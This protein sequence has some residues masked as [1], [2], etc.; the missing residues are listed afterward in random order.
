MPF[1]KQRWDQLW[2]DLYRW[3]SDVEDDDIVGEEVIHIWDFKRLAYDTVIAQRWD[4]VV[5]RPFYKNASETSLAEAEEWGNKMYK[6]PK[7][8]KRL[9]RFSRNIRGHFIDDMLKEF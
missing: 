8:V 5:T 2:D 4:N 1:N 9:Y 6:N 7:L 3:A